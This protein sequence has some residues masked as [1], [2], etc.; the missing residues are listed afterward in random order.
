MVFKNQRQRKAVMAKLAR[1]K[2]KR[3]VDGD[4]VELYRRLNGSKFVRIANV[5]TPERGQRGFHTAKRRLAKVE[6]KRLL[7]KPVG[8]SHGRTVAK[9]PYTKRLLEDWWL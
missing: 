4:T 7:M 8:K 5:N 9:V 6:G 2:V 3:A 1:R